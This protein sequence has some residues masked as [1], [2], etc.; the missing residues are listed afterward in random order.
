MPEE[1]EVETENLREAIHEELE[2]EGGALLRSV[3]LTTALLAALAAVAAQQAGGTA[4]EALALRTE[5]AQLQ[6]QASDQWAY[7][8]A[9]GIKAAVH[10]AAANAWRALGKSPPPELEA[11]ATTQVA[12]QAKIQAEARRL[13]K[14][15]DAKIFE[16]KELMHRHEFFAYAVALFQI[17]IALGAVTALTRLRALWWASLL[18]GVAGAVLVALTLVR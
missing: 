3:A 10:Q 9:K 2:K 16:S 14:E 1:P 4:N 5:A 15:R 6:T 12:E 18:M 7:Y 11:A 17:S 13:E 8:Q